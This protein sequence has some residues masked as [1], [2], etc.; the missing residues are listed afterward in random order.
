MATTLTATREIARERVSVDNA[1]GA[2]KRRDALYVSLFL[3]AFALRF[4][5]VLWKRTWYVAPGN[6]L[7][8]GAEIASIAQRIVEGRGFS[9]PFY[10]E[11]G[12]TAWISPVYPYLNALVFKLFGVF[13][14]A[15]AIALLLL[16][17]LMAGG[18]GV[19]IYAL[20]K[21]CFGEKV[22]LWSAW[23]WA[24]SPF[25]YRWPVSWIWDFTA[26]A[27]LVTVAM[28]V[29][30]DAGE[31]GTRRQWAGLGGIWGLIALTNPAPLSVL[32]FCFGYA[33]YE[34]RKAGKRWLPNLALACVV[35]GA[36]IAPWLVRNYV[37]FGQ[38]VF[39]RSN[40]WFEFHMGNYH[41]SNGAGYSGTHPTVNVRVL[42]QYKRL[43]EI[44]FI[45]H[46]KN[47]AF[48]FV[49]KYP[50]EFLTLTGQRALW[51]W[52]GYSLQFYGPPEWWSAWEFWPLSATGLL[53]LIFA[54]TRRPRGWF[55][56]LAA[57]MIY[58]IPYY[59][60]YPSVK[61]RHAIEPLLLLLS[62]YLASVLWKEFADRGSL[63]P[64]K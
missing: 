11:T 51:F 60:A 13:S 1:S 18:T 19:A 56:F 59:L 3:V 57:L 23:I 47:E 6:V 44:Q 53:G 28:I 40:Y 16:Q 48:Q 52:N 32:P 12:P 58:P 17:C 8:F 9:S 42:A 41:L 64:A 25:F 27:L 4:G 29:T 24:V 34:N 62:V 14:R 45:Q 5:F 54:L 21:R 22:A 46:D 55:L 35:F 31:K 15:S 43:G 30:L 20:G 39:L 63:K 36:M 49:K 38:P 50:G 61:Y 2:K 7:P 33:A 26:T 10:V 37:V